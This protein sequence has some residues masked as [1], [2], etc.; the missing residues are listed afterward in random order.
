MA[1]IRERFFRRVD[2]LEFRVAVPSQQLNLE[3]FGPGAQHALV[4]L[5]TT[6]ARRDARY[7]A[8]R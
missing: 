6:P 1:V 3:R 7:V 4:Q 5:V 8:A 2:C